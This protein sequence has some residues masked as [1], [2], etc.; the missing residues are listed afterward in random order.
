MD[1]GAH[2]H[3]QLSPLSLT[4][5]CRAAPSTCVPACL[6]PEKSAFSL[7]HYIGLPVSNSSL[8]PLRH[9]VFNTNCPV[10]PGIYH[11][12]WVQP[13]LKGPRIWAS[14]CPDRSLPTLLQRT[15]SGLDLP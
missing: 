12:K 3:P 11:E 10:F 1:R 13:E 8:A 9:F 14:H 4:H 15:H 6:C 5:I 7:G 2:S